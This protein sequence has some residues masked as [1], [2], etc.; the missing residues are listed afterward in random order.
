VCSPP[1]SGSRRY[2]AQ[3]PGRRGTAIYRHHGRPPWAP[4]SRGPHDT[5]LTHLSQL[6]VTH[7]QSLLLTPLLAAVSGWGPTIRSPHRGPHRLIQSVSVAF[8]RG[9]AFYGS[10]VLVRT[11]SR[12]SPDLYLSPSPHVPHNLVEET[13]VPRHLPA[14][15]SRGGHP[16]HS[17][18]AR[19]CNSSSRAISHWP[20]TLPL[21]C[22]KKHP[23]RLA[24]SPPDRHLVVCAC[25][26]LR[27]SQT[28]AMST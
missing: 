19:S 2:S 1:L 5:W 10:S 3:S 16:C 15:L 11:S 7:G 28:D 6:A 20:Q 23:G 14:R 26:F 17:L 8:C 27:F 9:K 22:C 18:A 24:F 13:F 12:F 25:S 21:P 4:M